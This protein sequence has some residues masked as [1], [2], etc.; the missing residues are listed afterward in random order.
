MKKAVSILVGAISLLAIIFVAVFGTKPQG[1]VPRIYIESLT[2]KPVDMSTYTIDEENGNYCTIKYDEDLETT[3][4]ENY[5]MP[6]IFTTEVLPNNVT[7]QS[8]VYSIADNYKE[9]MDFPSNNALANRR[10][11]FL[12]KKRTDK[13]VAMVRINVR[14]VDGGNGKGDS[15][16]IILDYRAINS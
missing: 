14:P 12:I 11:A 5:Y 10:G 8:F 9:Y 6:Y 16:R 1:I 4:G 3:D 2:I 15:L 7:D 13:K